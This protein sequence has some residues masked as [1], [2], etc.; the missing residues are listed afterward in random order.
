MPWRRNQRAD[1]A[2]AVLV[3][4]PHLG[5][6]E[7]EPAADSPDE[8]AGHDPVGLHP[9]VGVAVAVRHGLPGDLEHRLVALGGDVAEPVDLA[10]EQL[11][12]RDRGAVADRVDRGAAPAPI[13]PSTFS[14]PAMKPS[15]GLDGVV[16]VLVVT[17]SPVS[18]SKA[19]TSVNVPPVSM[20]TRIAARGIGHV[21]TPC[22][23]RW[24]VVAE[25]G[26]ATSR[27]DATTYAG[28]SWWASTSRSVGVVMDHEV[29]VAADLEPVPVDAEH[30]GGGG[31]HRVVHE[32]DAGGVDRLERMGR[33]ER[34][35]DH[36][37]PAERVVGVLD[38]VLAERDRDAHRG[39]LADR[40]VQRSGV[41]VAD[42]AEPGPLRQPGE[43]LE[44]R[45]R[46]QP[47]RAGVVGDAATDQPVLEHRRRRASRSCA[48]T[49]RRRR[50]RASPP[51]GRAPRRAS[52]SG[53]RARGPR[54][55][56]ARSTGCRRRRR[57]RGR[58]PRGPGPR[59][60]GRGAARPAGTPRPAGRPRRGTPRA[61]PA[62]GS[63]PRAAPWC[64]RRRT[65]ARGVRRAAPPRA[66]PCARWAR[67][68]A[69]R[70]RPSPPR[71]ARSSA[72]RTHV[73]R[74][75]R[76]QGGVADPVQRVDL[77]QV[78]VPVDEALGD[79][80]TGGVDLLAAR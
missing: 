50:R 61:A 6:G 46:V 47:D 58:P 4:R 34:D 45:A 55:R 8:V 17:S 74:G 21:S 67:S 36:V 9:E 72:A 52:T 10:L 11:V 48:G 80:P 23:S 41:R 60:P 16:G 32:V 79:Q 57:R 66:P 59:R 39:Q 13:R 54:R 53:V 37:V 22:S 75:V 12:G 18:S 29:G 27:P 44:R 25:V 77:V 1:R 71:P 15:A 43:P 3:E 38:V 2:G 64:R 63:P 68:S 30:V 65:P 62:A 78:H 5:A 20:P 42:E 26:D 49:R 76:R 31:R 56:C 51:G 40:Q 35:L 70:S 14:M 33:E 7:V 24:I 28:A 69:G 19:T 73:T